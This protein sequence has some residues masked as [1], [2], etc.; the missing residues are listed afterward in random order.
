MKILIRSHFTAN[1]NKPSSGGHTRD[2]FGGQ[3]RFPVQEKVTGEATQGLQEYVFLSCPQKSCSGRLL[4]DVGSIIIT[5]VG[6]AIGR[7]YRTSVV[8]ELQI[9]LVR[10]HCSC[11][12]NLVCLWRWQQ[13]EVMRAATDCAVLADYHT[14][15]SC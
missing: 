5:G 2:Q 3:G 9:G 14:Q 7:I 4:R 11:K 8:L 1:Y 10:A 15:E 6:H 13:P 12:G